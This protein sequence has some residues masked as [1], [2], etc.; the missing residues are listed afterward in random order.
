MYMYPITV[1]KESGEWRRA[2]KI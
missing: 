2:S 1:N